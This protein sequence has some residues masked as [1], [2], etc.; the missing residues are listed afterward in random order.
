M[1]REGNQLALALTETHLGDHE[2]AEIKIPGYK[3]FRQ[4]RKARLK[5]RRDSG[6][7]AL[8][9][10]DDLA[11][12]SEVIFDYSC[13]VI[14]AIAVN[15][16]LLNL[17]I[18]VVYRPPDNPG[19]VDRPTKP[20][21]RSTITKFRKFSNKLNEFLESLPSPTPDILLMGDFNLPSADWMSGECRAGA[22]VDEQAIVSNLYGL[23]I[24]H[25]LT[26]QIEG[27]THQAGNLLDLVF[28]NNPQLVHNFTATPTTLSDHYVVQINANYASM[29]AN[30]VDDDDD[31]VG[32]G[33]E[34]DEPKLRDFNFHSDDVNWESVSDAIAEVDWQSEFNGLSAADMMDKFLNV[35]TSI[36][37][38]LVPLRKP[39]SE[40][41][42]PKIPRHRRNLMRR[43]TRL[44]AAYNAATRPASKLATKDKLMK[45]EKD[46]QASYKAQELK[47]E[48]EA[49][50][51]I[52]TN[53]K[54]FFSYANK[55]SKLKTAI[56]PLMNAAKVLVSGPKKMAEMLS[57][58]YQSVFSQPKHPSTPPHQLFPDEEESISTLQDFD[59][60]PKDL[61]DAM[62][63]LSS[64]SA[65]GPDG[66]PAIL[67]KMCKKA[68]SLPLVEIWRKSLDDG[69]V[70]AI[71]KTANI[72]PIHKGKSRAVPANYR[73]V[74]L[75]SQLIKVFEKVVRRKV[76]V[77][78]ERQGHFNPTQHGFRSG[79]SCL[80]Q[81]LCH[82]DKVTSL[83][84]KG[85]GVDV[86]YLDFAK[87]FD[88]VDIGVVLRKLH[89]LGIRGKLGR[90]LT[91]FLTGRDQAVVINGKRS[92][93]QPVISGVPQGSVLGPLIFL[94]LIGDIDKDVL[95]SFLSSF[96]D[97]TRIGRGVE[98]EDEAR[99]LQSDLEAVFRWATENNMQ[100]NSD[101]FEVVRY[102]SKKSADVQ[103]EYASN[104]GQVIME[105]KMLTDL[106][107]TMSCDASFNQHV[108]SICSKVKKKAGWALRTFM[109][110][111]K[112]PML[113]IWKTLVIPHHDYCSQLWC[114]VKT[115]L[116]QSLELLQ[117]S[118][119]SKI[120]GMKQLSYWEQL[121][122][123]RL[124]SL[125]RRRE[126]YIL[127][128][129]WQILEELVPNLEDTTI[130]KASEITDR[131]GR[132]CHVPAVSHQAP[133]ALQATRAA[134]LGVRGVA[135][136]NA[137]PLNLRNMT[138]CRKDVFKRALDKFLATVP[139]E[140]L[141]PG[142]TA[143]R[144]CC[145]NSILDWVTALR[146]QQ[147]L[148]LPTNGERL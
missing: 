37:K 49:I 97:D 75:T 62:G 79:R 103:F 34:D 109:T 91:A 119:V 10:R 55:K 46:L 111:D 101:K 84:E 67:L 81:L 94:V 7:V 82:F 74:A 87:A 83:L 124:Y 114:P 4:D 148:A 135:L 44:E 39:K 47:E 52:K 66:I 54:F 50:G 5:A 72:V 132:V 98:S 13:G 86:I 128:Y 2:E 40:Q 70:P 88:K 3:P 131:R 6:G 27:S 113:T 18:I 145:S 1:L 106:G 115:G 105:K 29:D 11:I 45:I 141:I 90:W 68:L 127:L 30:S 35:I 42:S 57:Q 59:L 129:V 112:L 143:Q 16:E 64:S 17:C 116:T 73:P 61:E 32:S 69:T 24:A 144:R 71:C 122:T 117:R 8:Y 22:T 25:F 31:D 41:T 21:H 93:A 108:L 38:K 102:R 15:I 12:T 95:H 76:A 36:V 60:T 120:R 130:R 110:R 33:V 48:S 125:E 126:R 134:S 92:Q 140:P 56:G 65:A 43:R 77:H 137:L 19:T 63:D 78:L 147:D 118:F 26:Q 142:Y 139:D 20:E 23:T 96:A 99:L 89:S 28:T 14:E 51:R 136:F 100:F 123:L 107:V 133:P 121:K 80:S 104:N 58:Q 138:G 85:M 146:L 9:L 53:S